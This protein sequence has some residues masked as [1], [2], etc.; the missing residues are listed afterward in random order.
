MAM[1]AAEFWKRSPNGRAMVLMLADRNNPESVREILDW[2]VTEWKT[3]VKK[4]AVQRRATIQQ[5][6]TKAD[7]LSEPLYR[8]VESLNAT[9]SVTAQREVAIAIIDF[10]FIRFYQAGPQKY[11]A[12]MAW[13]ADECRKRFKNDDPR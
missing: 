3:D 12:A 1:T 2:L 5:A 11:A 4:D 8:Q 6:N 7:N 9:S 13:L 10:C